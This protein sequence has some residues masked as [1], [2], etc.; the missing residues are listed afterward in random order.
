MYKEVTYVCV[1]V[2][3]SVSH[4]VYP[5]LP[6]CLSFL[7]DTTHRELDKVRAYMASYSSLP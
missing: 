1:Y 7:H 5:C 2:L 6:L 4:H 3:T